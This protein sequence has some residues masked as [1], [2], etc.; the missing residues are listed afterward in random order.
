M[1]E[2]IVTPSREAVITIVVRG[3][4]GSEEQIEAT[5]DTGFSD[6]LTLPRAMISALGLPYRTSTTGVLADGRRVRVS[7]Y[8]AKVVWD[9]RERGVLV[10]DTGGTPLIGMALLHGQ[11]LVVDVVAGGKVAISPLPR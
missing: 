7:V 8:F 4:S 3:T 10:L 9:G 6:Y 11:R 5:V 1:M 2:W